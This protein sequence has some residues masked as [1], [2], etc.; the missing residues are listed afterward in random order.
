MSCLC[1]DLNEGAAMREADETSGNA[2]CSMLGPSMAR[3]SRQWPCAK[4]KSFWS[5]VSVGSRAEAP[6]A[7]YGPAAEA[8]IPS[9]GRPQSRD[10]RC[11]AQVDRACVWRDL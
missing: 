5:I 8:A 2:G 1:A 11:A 9:P 7:G 4:L 6:G 3:S 10:G